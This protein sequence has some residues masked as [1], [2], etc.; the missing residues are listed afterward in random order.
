MRNLLILLIVLLTFLGCKKVPKDPADYYPKVKM[1]DVSVQPDGSVKVRAQVLSEGA[2]ELMHAGFCMDTL[3]NPELLSGQKLATELVDNVFTCT[4]TSLSAVSKY[5]FRAFAANEDGYA[6][7]DVKE[8][9]GGGIDTA[10]IPCS[11]AFNTLRLEPSWGQ[12]DEIFSVV[13]EA[14]YNGL[15]CRFSAHTGSRSV[16]FTFGSRPLGIFTTSEASS[17]QPGY[18]W[19]LMGGYTIAAGTKVYIKQLTETSFDVWLC[20]ARVMDGS[21]RTL[22]LRLRSPY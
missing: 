20:N 2:S 8:L 11:L 13:E 5:Y 12:P 16:H 7:S 1:L 19:I 10:I 9:S 6:Y 4:Y 18:V 22:S 21:G 17:P 15:G 14:E 3:P